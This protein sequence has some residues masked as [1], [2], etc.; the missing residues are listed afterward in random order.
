MPAWHAIAFL[1]IEAVPLHAAF[2]RPL[3]EVGIRVFDIE[4]RPRL[5]R[6]SLTPHNPI[7]E[8]Q[9]RRVCDALL[10]LQPRADAATAAARNDGSAAKMRLLFEDNDLGAGLMRLQTR[11]DADRSRPDNHNICSP[12]RAFRHVQ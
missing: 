6:S 2:N 8:S 7:I 9:V 11:G 10:A 12:R 4:A 3:V 5:V 1:L